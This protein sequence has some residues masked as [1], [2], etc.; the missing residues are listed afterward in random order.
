MSEPSG[1]PWCAR[2][3]GSKSVSDLAEPFRSSVQR[4]LGA[5]HAGTPPATVA[6]N[7]TVRPPERAYLMHYAWLIAHGQI[8]PNAVPPMRGV[9]IV[10]NH[11][12][13]VPAADAMV[14]GYG[15]AFVAVPS[16]SAGSPS[17]ARTRSSTSSIP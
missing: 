16:C 5:L 12:S 7:A 8:A 14:H 2:F 10:W 4:F 9:D 17:G 15:M 13:A 6:I 3:P 11:A 1:L